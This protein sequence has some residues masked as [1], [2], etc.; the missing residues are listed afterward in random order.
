VAEALGEPLPLPPGEP[1]CEPDP[2]AQPEA[3]GEGEDEGEKEPVAVPLRPAL[4][5]REPLGVALM[6]ALRQ[7]VAVRVTLAVRECEAVAVALGERGGERDAD[8]EGVPLA[9][10]LALPFTLREGVALL[11]SEGERE[12][13]CEAKGEEE[14]VALRVDARDA[15]AHVGMDAVFVAVTEPVAEP[16]ELLGGTGVAEALGEALPPPAP[17]SSPPILAVT[18]GDA[19][20]EPGAAPML[21]VT[22]GDAVAEPE[23]APLALGEPEALGVAGAV[24]LVVAREELEA[25][26]FT[27]PAARARRELVTEA[28]AVGVF[29]SDFV[30]EGRGAGRG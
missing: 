1:L 24:K 20:A 5:L 19:V 10:A 17:P 12:A 26:A 29:D 22:V 15:E 6:L 21:A 18:V 3:R 7:V 13:R 11:D 23:A 8:G 14:A 16:L 30:D 27:Y 25:E 9:D 28:V 2:V 4:P